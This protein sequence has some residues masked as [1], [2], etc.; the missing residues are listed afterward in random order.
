[1]PQKQG[2]TQKNPY[3]SGLYE[4]VATGLAARPAYLL[5]FAISALFFL[6]GAVTTAK[7]V[8]SDDFR[9]GILALVSFVIAIGAAI[10][11]VREVEG[12]SVAAAPVSTVRFDGDADSDQEQ[13]RL[14]VDTPRA[15]K[16][17]EPLEP[18]DE[19]AL[20]AEL[21]KTTVVWTVKETKDKYAEGGL[22]RELH[23]LYEFETFDAAFHFMKDV[24]Q[25]AIVPY[26]HHPRWQNT[27]TRVEVWLTTFNL[28]KRL[29]IR[30]RRLAKLLEQIWEEH[31][32]DANKDDR[33]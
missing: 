21:N 33:E 15:G 19:R 12:K 8:I 27:F 30:D 7:A 28:G 11:I 5:V 25:R 29:S 2:K 20:L 13:E 16:L 17:P 18:K 14:P 32:K 24:T 23:R 3:S 22:R 26:N 1:M 6:S 4:R 31:T 10:I 9:F